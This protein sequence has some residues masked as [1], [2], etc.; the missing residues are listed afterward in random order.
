MS[1]TAYKQVLLAIV[2]AGA[3]VAAH[4]NEEEFGP[5]DLKRASKPDAVPYM[6]ISESDSQAGPPATFVEPPATV[7][8]EASPSPADRSEWA[9]D[10]R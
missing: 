2:F 5:S 8:D 6:V 10:W 9:D 4:A 7:Q 1:N 3:G